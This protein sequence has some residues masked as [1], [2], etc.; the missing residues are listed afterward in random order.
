MGLVM[1]LHLSPF[2]LFS[3][4]YITGAMGLYGV[5]FQSG[6]EVS[7]GYF[8]SACISVSVLILRVDPVGARNRHVT[9][10]YLVVAADADRN[11]CQAGVRGARAECVWSRIDRIKRLLLHAFWVSGGM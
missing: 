8:E 11:P 5:F 3:I 1:L 9:C 6:Q 10:T 7:T 2:F 4:T